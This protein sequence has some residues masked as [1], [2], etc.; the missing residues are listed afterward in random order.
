MGPDLPD[1]GAA[2]CEFLARRRERPRTSAPAHEVARI[3]T[4]T[5]IWS[6]TFRRTS[7]FTLTW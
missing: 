5:R 3:V 4:F 6:D 7:G 2:G 1:R